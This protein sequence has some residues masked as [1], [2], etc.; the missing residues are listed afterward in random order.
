MKFVVVKEEKLEGVYG[1]GSIFVDGEEKIVFTSEQEKTGQIVMVDPDSLEATLISDSPGG[2][3]NLVPLK[4]ENGSFLAIQAFYPIFKSQNAYIAWGRKNRDCYDLKNVLNL[5]FVHRIDVL[6][7]NGADYLIAATLCKDKKYIDDWDHPG[8]VYAGKINYEQ[9][10]IED[11]TEVLSG[12]FQNHGFSKIKVDGKEGLL[13]SGKCGVHKMMPPIGSDTQW[14]IETLIDTPTSDAVLA[15]IDGDGEL[16]LGI[17][18]SFH[19]D[20][21]KIL[22][23]ID[24]RWTMIYQLEGKHEFGHA[25]W[26][27]NFQGKDAFLIGFRAAGM[28]LYMITM[29]GNIFLT[30]M[31][32][33]NCGAT[34]VAV[35]KNKTHQLICVAN[36]QTDK[37]TIYMANE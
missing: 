15:D 26:G 20:E 27:G 18:T 5:P 32:D 9:Q 6:Q 7:I 8:S 12:V 36:G 2:G 17:I 13:V 25:I 1:A 3:M 29:D 16:E 23:E 24:G 28:Q 14:C 30:E 21:F 33:E 31:I 34:N 19:G 11:V 37:Y 22:K 4:K 10:C 35:I